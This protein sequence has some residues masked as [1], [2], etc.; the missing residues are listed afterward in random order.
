MGSPKL[1]R[2]WKRTWIGALMVGVLVALL[3]AVD[4][5]GEGWPILL[6]SGLLLVVGI[7]ELDRMGVL[8]GRGLG[9]VLLVPAVVTLQLVWGFLDAADEVSRGLAVAAADSAGGELRPGD[10]TVTVELDLEAPLGLAYARALLAA[11][12]GAQRVSHLDF[13]NAKDKVLLGAERRSMIMSEQD[14]RITAFH[15]AGH[16]LIALL[17]PIDSDPV[18]KVTI[19]PRGMALGLTQTLPEEDRLNYTKDQINAIIRYAMGGR[20]AED[21]V[22]D[23]FSTGASNDLEQATGWA[24]R[25]ICEYGM[26][27]KLGPVSYGEKGGDVFLGRDVMTRRDFSEKKSEEID[28]E[29]YEMLVGKYREAKQLLI[30]NRDKLDSIAEALLERE[31]LETKDL[32][33]L[34][35]GQS[36]PDLPTLSEDEADAQKKSE[37]EPRKGLGGVPDPEPMP[38]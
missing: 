25:M 19:I 6:V 18:H 28:D 20:A 15:E 3:L 36:L 24:R 29:V 35:E 1:A 21:I 26:S 17:T 12:R 16:A 11:R 14:K 22:F 9:L 7:Y 2:V 32:K 31:T 23:H 33:L 13:E 4:R 30:D 34:M 27:D 8:A 5:T 37:S 10:P 38:S